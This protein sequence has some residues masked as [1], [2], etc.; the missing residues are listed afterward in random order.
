MTVYKNVRLVLGEGPDKME[1][2]EAKVEELPDGRFEVTMT[3]DN[4]EIA[5]KL[6]LTSTTCVGIIPK[7]P[8]VDG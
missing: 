8:W 1:V 3:L 5:D 2:G 7:L 6:G 4:K